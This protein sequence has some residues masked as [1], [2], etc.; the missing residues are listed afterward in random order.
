MLFAKLDQ[1]SECQAFLKVIFAVR[2]DFE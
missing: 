1:K 2:N